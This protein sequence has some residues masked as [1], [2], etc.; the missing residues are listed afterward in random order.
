MGLIEAKWLF[1]KMKSY[2]DPSKHSVNVLA[3]HTS[4][5]QA[6]EGYNGVKNLLT[7]LTMRNSRW[8][9]WDGWAWLSPV[10]EPWDLLLRWGLDRTGDK[11]Q[12][13]Q[14]NAAELLRS[15]FQNCPSTPSTD[16]NMQVQQPQSKV[17][18]MVKS[19][20]CFL[21]L[22]LPESFVPCTFLMSRYCLEADTVPTEHS[23]HLCP[24]WMINFLF[25]ANQTNQIVDWFP[26]FWPL[27]RLSF[28]TLVGHLH[29]LLGLHFLTFV[30][31]W[32]CLWD[33][34][35]PSVHCGHSIGF[36]LFTALLE[37]SCLW[38]VCLILEVNNMSVH[39]QTL[40]VFLWQIPDNR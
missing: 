40:F 31:E 20:R 24:T 13:E 30:T 19:S 25:F 7:V 9:G 22:P 27:V 36:I 23:S 8:S 3:G 1:E 16:L 29:F 32:N 39:T 2:A 21:S 26:F 18:G 37:T 33:Q 12:Q 15:Q 5:D 17:T 38:L 6:V 14:P 34:F 10:R 35:E 11:R 4:N 28:C